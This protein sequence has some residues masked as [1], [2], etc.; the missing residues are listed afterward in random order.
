MPRLVASLT[1]VLGLAAASGAWAVDITACG[2]EV[3]ARQTG[4]LM[5]DLN[6]GWP[7]EEPSFGVKLGNHAILDLNGHS[8]TGPRFAIYCPATCR[9]D[10]PG[11]VTGAYYG[12]WAFDTKASRADVTGVT[13]FANLGGIAASRGTL[14]DVTATDNVLAMDVRKL[15]GSNLTVTGCTGGSAYCVETKVGK[16]DGFQI[17]GNAA[18]LAIFQITR[19]LTLE[20]S[21]VSGNEAPIGLLSYRRLQLE[22]ST[23]TGH[24]VDLVS[25][26]RPR[27]TNS[28]CTLSSGPSIDHPGWD[29]CTDD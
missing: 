1:F 14:T 23:V 12:I 22:N 11:T 4:V 15:R 6:C 9:I 29:V 7:T 28:T 5:A 20:N 17:T 27:V 18:S 3:P 26:T 25:G 8:I 2:Q 10:G 16:V 21:T 19:S 24:G 13:L